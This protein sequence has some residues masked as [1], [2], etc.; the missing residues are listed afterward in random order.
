MAALIIGFMFCV[1]AFL[2]FYLGTV[3]ARTPKKR[4]DRPRRKIIMIL[5]ILLASILFVC[6]I[7]FVDIFLYTEM[8]RAPVI[9]HFQAV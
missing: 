5:A 8:N 3:S 1:G 2:V 4:R 6:G 7:M 9:S